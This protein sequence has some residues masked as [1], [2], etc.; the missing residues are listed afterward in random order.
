[1]KEQLPTYLSKPS[2]S[3]SYPKKKAQSLIL[4]KEDRKLQ[5]LGILEYSTTRLSEEDGR[6]F[7]NEAWSALSETKPLPKQKKKTCYNYKCKY[8]KQWVFDEKGKLEA[9]R[10]EIKALDR[11]QGQ[12]F[13]Q[14]AL[15]R[16]M[17]EEKL[18]STMAMSGV[19]G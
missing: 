2:A 11:T 8:L 6:N 19:L 15:Q 4:G 10:T 3:P 9:R 7:F 14:E 5:G 12:S 1:M 16:E 18:V 13:H 17:Q